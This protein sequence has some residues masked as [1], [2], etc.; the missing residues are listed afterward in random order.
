MCTSGTS[1]STSSSTF[2]K[3]LVEYCTCRPEAGRVKLR[4]SPRW[5]GL[6]EV[7][8][9]TQQAPNRR[10]KSSAFRMADEKVAA[11]STT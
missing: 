3:Y 5:L 7:S 1:V 6:P 10:L 8:S 9:P 2:L 4:T 11:P